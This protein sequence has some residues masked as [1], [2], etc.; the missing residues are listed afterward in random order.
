M[1]TEFPSEKMNTES[2]ARIH[3]GMSEEAFAEAWEQ[4]RAMSVDEAVELALS[5]LIGRDP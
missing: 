1:R 3:A 4:G 2:L 5:A